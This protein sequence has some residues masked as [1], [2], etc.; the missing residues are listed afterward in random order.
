MIAQDEAIGIASNAR[1]EMVI[2][3]ASMLFADVT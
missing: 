2:T 3:I 1:R